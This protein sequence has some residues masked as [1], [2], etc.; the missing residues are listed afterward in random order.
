MFKFNRKSIA[1]KLSLVMVTIIVLQAILLIGSVLASGVVSSI[2][3]NAYSALNEKVSN[4]KNYL[5]NEMNSRFSNI[6]RYAY[7]I[8]SVYDSMFDA[9]GWI[10]DQNADAFLESITPN[11]LDMLRNTMTTGSFIILDNN[12]TENSAHSGVYLKDVDPVLNSE[13]NKDIYMLKGPVA[14][15]RSLLIPLEKTWSYGITMNEQQKS[16]FDKPY[17]A[18]KE[19]DRLNLLGYW[20]VIPDLA[21]SDSSTLTYTVPLISSSGAAFGVLGVEVFQDYLY[22]ILPSNEL[23]TDQ[24]L[25]YLIGRRDQETQQVIPIL[26][27]GARQNQIIHINEPLQLSAINEEFNCYYIGDTKNNAPVICSV[28][29]IKLY[30][31][32]TPFENEQWVIIGMVEEDAILGFSNRFIQTLFIAFTVSIVIGVLVVFGGTRTF[33]KPIIAL[34]NKVRT[35]DPNAVAEMGLIGLSEIDDLSTAIVELNQNVID[36]SLKTDKIIGMVNLPL[37]TFEYKKGA[38]FVTCSPNLLSILN[39]SINLSANNTIEQKLFFDKISM[40]MNRIEDKEN[41]FYLLSENPA[42]WVKIVIVENEN[43]VLGVV[44][45]VTYQVL[46]NNSIKF[47][48]DYD[49]LTKIYNRNAF[50][51]ETEEI[52]VQGIRR[53]AAF[54]MFDLDNLKYINDVYGHDIGDNYI[55]LAAQMLTRY[56]QNNAVVG[57]MSGDEFYVFL[58]DFESKESVWKLLNQMY[59]GFDHNQ[60]LLPNGEGFKLR[61]SGGISWYEDDATALDELVKFADF[62]MYQGKHSIK[63]VVREFDREVYNNEFFMLSGR[64]ELNNILDNQLLEFV[65]QPIVSAKTGEIYAYESLM[66]PQSEVLSTPLK[67]IQIAKSQSNLWKIEKLTF[68]K[69]LATYSKYAHLFN[70]CKIFINSVPNEKLKEGEYRELE[71][72]YPNLLKNVVIEIIENEKL[73]VSTLAFKRELMDRWG[74]A[75]ALDDYGSGYNGDISLLRIEPNIVKIDRL[76]IEGI[77]NDRNRQSIIQKLIRYGKEQSVLILAEGIETKGQMDKV[78]SMGVDLLQGFYIAYP[79]GVPN[80]DNSKIALEIQQLQHEQQKLAEGLQENEEE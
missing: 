67:L 71:R 70:N 8:V 42:A 16:I 24:S 21:G 73:D 6:T 44:M 43:S 49:S 53:V 45:D 68:F 31:N 74:G 22:N 13:A 52:F 19:T 62:A 46:E 3:T 25:G 76:L 15:S 41:N 77:E 54:L 2:Q 11:I 28:N 33:V 9:T 79:D 17:L 38:G 65:F 20:D 30:N 7:D 1:V 51:R 34:A 61:M 66:R 32:N 75:L 58:H 12:K 37:G 4:R 63:G 69:T 60:L 10:N 80:F 40:I 55:K 29:E 47:E 18:A 50:R 56:M 78:I 27:Q 57:R 64:E 48:R 5:Q 36:V 14:V 23:S 26:S 35:N 59:E 72:L 39:F